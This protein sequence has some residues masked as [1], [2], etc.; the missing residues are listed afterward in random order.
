MQYYLAYIWVTYQPT[1]WAYAFCLVRLRRHPV[2]SDVRNTHTHTHTHTH[3]YTHTHTHTHTHT[4]K[5]K[6][7]KKKKEEWESATREEAQNAPRELG[8]PKLDK[9]IYIRLIS[10]D[11]DSVP[12]RLA[13]LLAKPLSPNL[14][15][16][17]D[18]QWR[19]SHR[20]TTRYRL[21]AKC[22]RQFRGKIIDYKCPSG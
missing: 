6:K 20:T 4:Y 14:G 17:N 19:R 3:T 12:H 15:T 2:S 22:L 5:R 10:S 11:S 1:R 9:N 21:A 18:V 13:K 16:P 8:L 7:N